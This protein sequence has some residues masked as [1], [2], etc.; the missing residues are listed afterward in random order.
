MRGGNGSRPQAFDIALRR[1]AKQAAVLAAELRGA[2]IAHLP[3]VSTKFCL[4]Q[5]T[6]F[7]ICWLGDRQHGLPRPVVSDAGLNTKGFHKTPWV[8]RDGSKVGHFG[9]AP[10]G[11]RL[12]VHSCIAQNAPANRHIRRPFSGGRELNGIGQYSLDDLNG[13]NAPTV[14]Q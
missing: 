9:I 6:A 4:S 7:A 5:A 13:I 11:A 2:L 3:S 14:S 12:P 8:D 1:I 10:H